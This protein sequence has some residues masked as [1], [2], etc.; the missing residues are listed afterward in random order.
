MRDRMG[1][2][3]ARARGARRFRWWRRAARPRRACALPLAAH[4]VLTDDAEIRALN[5]RTRGVDRATDVLS[6]PTVNYPAGPNRAQLRKAPA[7]RVRPRAG[8]V[9]LGDIVI[10]YPRRA[11]SR[12]PSTATARAASCATCWPTGCFT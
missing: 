12:P 5:A 10:S 1:A 6:F 2:A 8:R 4:V 11:W 9:P 3:R 7:R